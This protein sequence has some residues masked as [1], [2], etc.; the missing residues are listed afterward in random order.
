MISKLLISVLISGTLVQTVE[1]K[2][3]EE[4]G[5]ADRDGKQLLPG[6]FS[7]V[8]FPNEQCTGDTTS[9]TGDCITPGECN[10]RSGLI[11]GSCAR[12]FGT[13]CIIQD[14]SG[15]VSVE[16]NNTH[17]QNPGY[18]SGGA[19][20]TAFSYT[21]T[22]NRLSSDICFIRLDFIKFQIAGPQVLSETPYT[23]CSPCYGWK[24]SVDYLTFTTPTMSVPKVCG[25]LDG[26]HMYIDSSSS[27][28]NSMA[29]VG[30]GTTTSR[31]WNIRVSQIPCGTIYTPPQGCLQYMTGF[32]GEVY[33]FNYGKSADTN[34]HLISQEYSICFRRE[35][36]YCKMSYFP[37]ET[38]SFYTSGKPSSTLARAGYNGC[39]K[40]YVSIVGGRMTKMASCN[41]PNGATPSVQRF[42]GNRFN[43][44]DKAT[45]NSVIYSDS[46]PF[47]LG[48][49][50][51][52]TEPGGPTSEPNGNGNNYNRGFGLKYNQILCGTDV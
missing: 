37:V 47:R 20:K 32:S 42:C 21:Y 5:G 2:N 30:T 48:V 34:H 27:T 33:S 36:G 52:S 14:T 1:H 18:S 6:L 51:T 16:Y 10:D 12:G 38:A 35:K 4:E 19:Y 45:V 41:T 46:I 15:T 31:Y 9:L 8:K 29:L 44:Y 22:L 49:F 11:D 40:D 7:I 39:K 50:F 17:L 13:C 26:H 28:A 3:G 23:S 24:C 25:D 43:C